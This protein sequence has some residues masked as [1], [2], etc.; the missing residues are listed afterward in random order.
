MFD[1]IAPTYERVNTLLS[2]GRDR[3][4]RRRAVQLATVGAADDVLDIA[5]GTGDFSRAFANARPA[6]TIG[7]DFSENMLALAADR[8]SPSINWCRADAL[9]LPFADSSFSIV[10][11]AFGVRNFSDLAAGLSE[12][13]RVLRSGGRAV[14][15]EFTVPSSRWAGGLYL[16]YFRRILPRLAGWLSRDRTGAY[17]YLPSS[18]SSF[19]DAQ[20]MVETLRRCG[21]G[22]V[23]RHP[24]TMGIVTVYLAWK[25]DPDSHN[26]CGRDAQPGRE[27]NGDA[28][29]CG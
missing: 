18:V 14:I 7:S 1:A 3:Y 29:R 25:N 8:D 20:G 24:L 5:C 15:L 12:A 26:R 11:C 10:S 6:R 9:A 28:S 21:F 13:W 4:W 22:R 16:F 17:Q 23:E 2:A 19:V 27:R